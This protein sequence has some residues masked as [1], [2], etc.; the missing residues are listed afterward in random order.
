MKKEK[1]L[2]H[3][4][5]ALLVVCLNALYFY[6]FFAL[7]NLSLTWL[8]LLF[9]IAGSLSYFLILNILR[10]RAWH[11]IC[12][13]IYALSIFWSLINYA[14]FTVFKN[15]VDISFGQI[16]QVDLSF[17]DMLKD[18]YFL[19]PW[20]LYVA[21]GILTFGVILNSI[22][23]FKFSRHSTLSVLFNGTYSVLSW[24]KKRQF[25]QIFIWLVVFC[26]LN[27]S[28]F[29][30]CAYLANFP[31]VTWWDIEKQIADLGVWGHLYNQVYA[32]IEGRDSHDDGSLAFREETNALY[33]EMSRLA[34]SSQKKKT[35]SLPNFSSWP[36]VIVI[37][38]ESV[39][40]WAVNNEPSPMPFLKSLIE[41]NIT[42][43]HFHSNGCETINAEFASLCSFWPDSYEPINFSHQD[44]RYNCLP[45]VL[46]EKFGYGTYFFHSDVPEFWDRNIMSPLWGFEQLYFAPYYRLKADDKAVF[47]DALK[48]LS[49]APK[50][51][52]GY[53]VSFTSHS[54]HNDDM[55]AYNKDVNKIEIKPFEGE[56][57]AEN[58]EAQMSEKDL[59]KFF[60]FLAASDD[61]LRSFFEEFKKSGLARDTIVVIYSDHRFYSFGGDEVGAFKSFNEMPFV[62]VLPD[63]EQGQIANL[64]SHVDIAP[65]ILN[66]IEGADY[67]PDL[68]FIGTSLFSP[69]YVEQAVNKCLGNIYYV[70]NELIIKGS[71]RTKLY[72]AIDSKKDMSPVET[73]NWLNLIDRFVRLSDETLFNDQ[74][75][76]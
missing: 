58:H 19:I 20:E 76:P 60:G 2:I 42:I 16:N 53:M 71:A 7:L 14:Y 26:V 11:I 3:G 65:T 34:D 10:H 32:K 27:I 47:L 6:F 68:D 15:F 25:H 59:R 12:Y 1:L 4:L 33:G 38:L 64:A 67:E 66:I 72:S 63:G 31:R 35:I 41:N 48:T 51:F 44:K 39:G 54:P 37:Q 73:K 69:K 30:G 28:V 36:N 22:F 21:A 70:N 52:L 29:L 46:S 43:P 56:I 9:I 18:F 45:S 24:K 13:V 55:I 62:M 61:G 23:Y 8:N 57:S 74:L 40:N 49:S 17:L 5:F 75:I 50:P